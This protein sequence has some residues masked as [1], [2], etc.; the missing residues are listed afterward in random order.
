[1]DIESLRR[2]L[3]EDLELLT[4]PFGYLRAGWPHF[5]TFFARD[6][7]VAAW[8][9]LRHDPNVASNTLRFAV[10]FQ[11]TVRHPLTE[12][13]PGKMP[14]QVFLSPDRIPIFP[15]I[16]W[17]RR[18]YGSIDSTPLFLILLIE[19]M[20]H[21]P[22]RAIR[23]VRDIETNVR[24][25]FGWLVDRLDEEGWLVYRKHYVFGLTHQGW[26][27]GWRNRIKIPTP[28]ALLDVQAYA[29]AALMGGVELF[30]NVYADAAYAVRLNRVA[31][32]LRERFNEAF[33]WPEEE[34]YVF[35]LAGEGFRQVRRITPEPAM[36][37]FSGIVPDER[38]PAVVR[39]V[40]RSDIATPF[41]IRTLSD[42]DARFR[43]DSY[44]LGSVWPWT[45]WMVWKGLLM[46][47]FLKEADQIRN[48]LISAAMKLGGAFET[49]EVTAPAGG[50]AGEPRIIPGVN[51][52]QAWSAAGILDMLREER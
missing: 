25:A 9:L 3:V 41:G 51:P 19:F 11:G 39:R 8:Q 37:I 43:S 22:D 52:I 24:A 23:F 14:H 31:A 32:D 7:F 16:F 17:G 10:H 47:G 18:Y 36:A 21:D 13:E 5:H 38:I 44:F 28:V 1:M 27:D 42:R 26:R 45:N 33:W 12:E 40:L 50:V 15:R 35:A 4:S 48:A 30:R 46:H 2:K 20:R 34:Y 6:A 49:Y 29:Y